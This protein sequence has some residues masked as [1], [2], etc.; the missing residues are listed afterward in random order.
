MEVRALLLFS[1][2]SLTSFFFTAFSLCSFY[3]SHSS[4]VI[5]GECCFLIPISF[6]SVSLFLFFGFVM[7]SSFH[8]P[9]YSSITKQPRGKKLR[10]SFPQQLR[11]LKDRQ[12]KE[13]IERKHHR[14]ENRKYQ[15]NHKRVA[16]NRGGGIPA[17]KQPNKR[18]LITHSQYNS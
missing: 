13:G 12:N 18:N 8:F 16:Q 4:V 14:R 1:S 5:Y 9:S 7:Y 17:P 2:L 6:S 3:L 15:I 11:R 10:D